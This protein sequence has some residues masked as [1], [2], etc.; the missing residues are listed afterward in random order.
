MSSSLAEYLAALEARDER[1]QAHAVYVNACKS[2]SCQMDADFVLD[3]RL[4]S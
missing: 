3:S 4:D 1:E 2:A